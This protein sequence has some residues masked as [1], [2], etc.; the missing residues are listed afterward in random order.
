[1]VLLQ[2]IAIE[3][4]HHLAIFHFFQFASLLEDLE[5]EEAMA[6]KRG[7]RKWRKSKALRRK[8]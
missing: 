8:S 2:R 5:E 3:T 1:M 6:N 4:V 7:K